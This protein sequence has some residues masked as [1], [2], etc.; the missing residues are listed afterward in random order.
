MSLPRATLDIWSVD[1][2]TSNTRGFS[3]SVG[4]VILFSPYLL[5]C[6]LFFPLAR[7]P[8]GATLITEFPERPGA[9]GKFL[10]GMKPDWNI[11]LFHYRNHGA[12]ESNA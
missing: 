2:A 3:D 5:T 8:I 11:S 4:I 7:S 9:L 6:P 1:E 12:G 10:A